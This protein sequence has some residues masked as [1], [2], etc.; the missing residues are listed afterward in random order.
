M[1]P[2]TF[3]TLRS[4]RFGVGLFAQVGEIVKA[5]IGDRIMVVTDPG[6]I[7]TGLVDRALKNP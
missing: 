1:K 2:F 6:M 3:N 4:I 7:A 5:E